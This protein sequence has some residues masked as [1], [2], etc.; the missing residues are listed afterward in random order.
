M[1][2][3]NTWIVCNWRSCR[4]APA[5]FKLNCGCINW[6]LQQSRRNYGLHLCH[7]IGAIHESGVRIW[8]PNCQVQICVSV[9]VCSLRETIA[10]HH[11]VDVRLRRCN[12]LARL[13][14]QSIGSAQENIDSSALLERCTH[15]QI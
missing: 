15:C 12:P 4:N 8:S 6:Y 3:F 13:G 2:V 9:K 1:F 14:V 5:C 7:R 11:L 10:E